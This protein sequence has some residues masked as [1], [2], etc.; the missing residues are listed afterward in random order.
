MSECALDQNQ[1]CAAF[2]Q[3]GGERDTWQQLI[4]RKDAFTH[5]TRDVF[6]PLADRLGMWYFKTELETLS[7]AVASP[8]EFIEI[9]TTLEQVRRD[10]Q[11]S[12]AAAQ[13]KLET[14]LAA[15]PVLGKHVRQISVR[16]RVKGMR[17]LLEL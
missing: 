2:Q 7:L 6:L 9:S 3:M 17:A 14:V 16:S 5:Q 4:A 11:P 8:R 12:L 10:A 13:A 15:D 1:A